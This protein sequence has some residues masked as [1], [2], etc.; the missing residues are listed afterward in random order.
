MFFIVTPF[1]I[2]LSFGLVVFLQCPIWSAP[3]VDDTS[4]YLSYAYSTNIRINYEMIGYGYK[5]VLLLHGFGASLHTWD[6]I[7][8][9]FPKNEFTLYLIDMKGFC[10]SSKP[11][12]ENYTIQEQSNIVVQ[13]IKD[14]NADSLYIIGHSY[15]GAVALL[16]QISLLNEMSK[17]RI[18][19]LI[20]I[21]CEYEFGYTFITSASQINLIGYDKILNEY[22][23]IQTSCLIIWGKND[24]ILSVD[25]GIR[26]SNDLP[27]SRLE[28][29]DECGHVPQEEK[30]AATFEKIYAF[31]K[32]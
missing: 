21:D 25:N 19:K 23:E 27:N 13:F 10:N 31:I 7:K 11:A 17:T 15:G 26:L 24:L 3:T 8:E 28:I 20:L 32:R 22:K 2:L 14:I 6:K 5:K 12:D 1:R 29:M 18:S 4:Q 16:T 9:L 30:P